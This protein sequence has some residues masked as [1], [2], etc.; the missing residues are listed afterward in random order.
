MH[1]IGIDLGGTK[2]S[3]AVFNESGH[4]FH[5]E[6]ALLSGR[7][8]NEVAGLLCEL[9]L[10][11]LERAHADGLIIESMGVAVP[12]IY[13][14]ASGKVWAPNIPGWDEF[15]L[16]QKIQEELGANPL[17]ITIESDRSCYI[18]GEVWQGAASGCRDAIFLAIGTGIGAGIISGGNLIHGSKDIAGALGWMAL[19]APYQKKFQNFGNLEYYASGDGLLRAAREFMD[20]YSGYKGILR[21]KEK[22][23]GADIFDAWKQGDTIASK[24]IENA[25]I[26]WGMTVAN[27]VSIFNPEKII[28][29]GGVFGPAIEL[30]DDIL[31]EAIKW[32]QP[33]SI[34][35]V[36]LEES[37]LKGDAGLYG[38]AYLALKKL[39]EQ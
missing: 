32:A 12:G 7:R 31:K 37:L 18:L 3:G 33:L 10:K 19:S 28:I 22:L 21:L 17:K 35:M 13:F 6:S 4:L 1:L 34:K 36:S 30:L 29:G 16:K 20:E 23:N 24:V 9:I 14:T 27:L 25:V 26:L 8:G 2:I 38:A 39:D 15:P 5:K 11:L